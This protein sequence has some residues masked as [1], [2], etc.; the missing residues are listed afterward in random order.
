MNK[1]LETL[2]GWV[3]IFGLILFG[4]YVYNAPVRA[5]NEAQQEQRAS[6]SALCEKAAY[7]AVVAQEKNRTPH[8]LNVYAQAEA[9]DQIGENEYVVHVITQVLTLTNPTYSPYSFSNVPKGPTL[10]C[11][12]ANGVIIDSKW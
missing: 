9:P 7:D 1:L 5:K 4:V 6:S 3:V 2:F 12:I 10:T 11:R 8:F